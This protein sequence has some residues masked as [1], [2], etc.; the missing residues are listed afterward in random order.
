MFKD[1]PRQ[2]VAPFPCILNIRGNCPPKHVNAVSL[3]S[4]Q[5]GKIDGDGLVAKSCLTLATPW[6]VAHQTPLSVH[7]TSLARMLECISFSSSQPRDQTQVSCT[8]LGLLHCRQ[9]LYQ[10]SHQGS[11]GKI[12]TAKNLCQIWRHV[13]CLEHVLCTVLLSIF[14][15]INPSMN[16][17]SGTNMSHVKTEKQHC[18]RCIKITSLPCLFNINKNTKHHNLFETKG[19]FALYYEQLSES[20]CVLCPLLDWNIYGDWLNKWTHEWIKFISAERNWH[21]LTVRCLI[22]KMRMF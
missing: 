5:V 14:P 9:I 8:K 2:E 19:I 10:L 4:Y 22:Q 16:H 3:F 15:G 7:G 20:E 1:R 11:L 6:T 17:L 21:L 12:R 18:G 13:N